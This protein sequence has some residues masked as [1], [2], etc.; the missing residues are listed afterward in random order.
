MECSTVCEAV[1]ARLDGEDPGV[2]QEAIEAHLADCGACRAW[3]QRAYAVTR[4]G[5]LTGRFLDHDLAPRVLAALPDGD[6]RTDRPGLRPSRP[7]RFR[8]RQYW[9]QGLR[10]PEVRRRGLVR[11]VGLALIATAQIAI[12]VPLL[13]FGHDHGT[14]I[15]AAHELGA[16]DLAL[17]VAFAVGAF[18]PA[19][20][21]G[22]AWPC[23][24]AALGLA[25]TAIIDVLGGQTFGADEAQHLIA[26]AGAALLAWQARTA[27]SGTAA[28]AAARLPAAPAALADADLPAAPAVP[29][30]ADLPA[31]PGCAQD[32]G[33][34]HHGAEDDGTVSRRAYREEADGGKV[35]IA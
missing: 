15:H 27:G 2:D 6:R 35:S 17:A 23:G 30:D 11:R 26:V 22:L 20:S 16:F 21:A 24:V 5:R 29:A 3:R 13:L 10:R 32:H 25:S 34:G 8:R 4:R 19:L 18:R 28:P 33:A 7:Q 31:E 12:T 14:G 1:S 9:P